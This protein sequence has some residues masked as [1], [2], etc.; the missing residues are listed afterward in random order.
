MR[1]PFRASPV[2]V[3]FLCPMVVFNYLGSVFDNEDYHSMSMLTQGMK[4]NLHIW[5]SVVTIMFLCWYAMVIYWGL[6]KNHISI[7]NFISFL[8]CC[9]GSA[10]EPRVG[11]CQYAI[12]L[13]ARIGLTIFV[14]GI[15][16]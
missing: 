9:K 2:F 14:L 5:K 3:S 12:K 16:N 6:K 1:K 10:N 13:T 15:G 11:F 8:S 7:Q 4:D